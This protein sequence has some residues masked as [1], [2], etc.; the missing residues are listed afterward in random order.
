MIKVV[1][2]QKDNQIKE[3][4]AEL[5]PAYLSNGWNEYKTSRV[6][7]QPKNVGKSE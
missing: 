6:V 1:K 2:V 7:E 5:L 3:I 4:E